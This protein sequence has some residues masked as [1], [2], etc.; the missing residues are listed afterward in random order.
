MGSTRAGCELLGNAGMTQSALA[1]AAQVQPTAI[2]H[3]ESGGRVPLVETVRALA[4]ALRLARVDLLDVDPD[5]DLTLQE[6]PAD[7][8]APARAL[9]PWRRVWIAAAGS[10][11]VT[12]ACSR[13]VYT[14]AVALSVTSVDRVAGACTSAPGRNRKQAA[15][16]QGA[17]PRADSRRTTRKL[18]RRRGLPPLWPSSTART[19]GRDVVT[20]VDDTPA[21]SRR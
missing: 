12:N 8:A 20:L 7:T 21:D 11:C 19:C 18:L 14:S 4:D 17:T 10:A 1:L 3:R 16:R 9:P 13:L 2:A 15:E 6:L 5:D